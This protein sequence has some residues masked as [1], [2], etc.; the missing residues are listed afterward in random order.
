MLVFYKIEF[1]DEINHTVS[2]EKGITYCANKIE[3]ATRRIM[4]FYGEK[5]VFTFEIT[6]CEEI[7]CDEEIKALLELDNE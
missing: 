7:L 6:P 2:H 1:W 3:R 4:D 5:N